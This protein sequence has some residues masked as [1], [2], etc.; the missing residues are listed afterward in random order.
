MYALWPI[1]GDDAIEVFA[2][3]SKNMEQQDR[4]FGSAKALG[5][6]GKTAV[7]KLGGEDVMQAPFIWYGVHLAPQAFGQ[8]AFAA[9]VPTFEHMLCRRFSVRRSPLIH[10]FSVRPTNRITCTSRHDLVIRHT[11]S[12]HCGDSLKQ[13]GPHHAD[14]MTCY[15]LY[16]EITRARC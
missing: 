14:S 3:M 9:A 6:D 8:D 15:V 12:S 16:T 7:P 5:H 10:D 4:L 2:S 11:P 13:S 1:T